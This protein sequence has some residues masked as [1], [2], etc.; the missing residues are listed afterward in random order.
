[1]TVPHFL[2]VTT[3][4]VTREGCLLGRSLLIYK[5]SESPW[6]LVGDVGSDGG[7]VEDLTISV[8]CFLIKNNHK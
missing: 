1:V 4:T 5:A 6:E 7:G 3:V 8:V 2:I